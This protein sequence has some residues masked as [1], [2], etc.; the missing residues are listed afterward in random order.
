[1][2]TPLATFSLHLVTAI[3]S[4]TPREMR[5][6]T[7]P[8]FA[9]AAAAAA[10]ASASAAAIF[11]AFHHA[12]GALKGRTAWRKGSVAAPPTLPMRRTHGEFAW[13]V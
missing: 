8:F 12:K 3:V 10:A 5:P 6:D 1:M 2:K 13:I 9:A 4:L 11:F 7:M